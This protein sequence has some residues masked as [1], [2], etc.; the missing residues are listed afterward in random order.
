MDVTNPTQ[1]LTELRK[2]A[3]KI[4]DAADA[5][6]SI[7]ANLCMKLARGFQELDQAI[8]EG[9]DAPSQWTDE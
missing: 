6:K 7:D 9:G 2:I 8:C 5:N 3:G 1:F 4:T